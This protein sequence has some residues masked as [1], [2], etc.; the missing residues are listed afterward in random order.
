MTEAQDTISAR[1]RWQADWCARLGSP[2]YAAILEAAA[3]DV[4][5]GGAAWKLLAGRER[6]AARSFLALRLTGAVHRLVLMGRLPELAALY[7]SAGG[8][9]DVERAPRKFIEA[10]A[11]HPE[12]VAA[13]LDRP[14]QT[15]EVGRCA[16]LVGGFMVVADETRLPLAVLEVGASAGLNLRFDR[17]RYS[18]GG[19]SW[20]DLESPVRFE[21]VFESATPP[22]D[23]PL[24]VAERRGCDASP[25]DPRSSEDR[26]TL[27]SYVW[28]DQS[29]RFGLLEA[30]LEVAARDEVE[31]ERAGAAAWAERALAVRRPGVATVLYHSIVVQY[32]S[33]EEGEALHA[34]IV[35]AGTRATSDAPFAWLFLEPGGDKT[36][37]RLTLWPLDRFSPGEEA[38]LLA[39]AGYHSSPV[40]WLGA[41]GP[42]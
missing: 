13:H 39:R 4:R 36:D 38:R 1:L 19:R 34:A 14:V 35:A 7:P 15:N 37:V 29:A 24:T 6:E 42:Q 40:E 3:D 17:Y 23:A 32:L 41:P 9:A 33:P 12:E 11:G 5:R 26:L 21:D 2:L 25:L 20:G 28:P 16:G 10:L 30:A 8:E 18:S 22:L 27:M 31:V